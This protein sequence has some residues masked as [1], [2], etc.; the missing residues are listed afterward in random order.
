MLGPPGLF[1]MAA[2][3]SNTVLARLVGEIAAQQTVAS[4][5]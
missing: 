4:A 2:C 1:S 3:F 5:A